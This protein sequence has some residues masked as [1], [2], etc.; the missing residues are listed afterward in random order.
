MTSSHIRSA[1]RFGQGKWLLRLV[2]GAILTMLAFRT[3]DIFA[4][5]MPDN[6][7]MLR[8]QQV[9][10]LMAG[11]NWFDVDQARFLTPEGGEMHWSRL[12]DIFIAAIIYIARPFIGQSSAEALAASLWPLILL[13]WTMAA[14]V[15]VMRHLK[16][17]LA[18]QI[19][20]LVF[21]GTSGA[22]YS[23]WPGRIDHHGFVVALCL[24]AFAAAL[25][26]RLSAKSGI[27]AAICVA[28]MVTIALEGLPYAGSLILIFGGMWIV[29]G[30]RDGVRLTF[31]GLFLAI[32]AATF[33]TLDAPGWGP[34]R[35]VCDAYGTSH[36][37][38]LTVGGLLLMLLGIFGG[39]LESWRS[40]LAA[41]VIAGALTLAVFVWVQPACLGDPYAGVSDQVRVAW[42]SAV[43]E[44]RSLPR[45]W[46]DE[47]ARA[48]WQVGFVVSGFGAAFVMMLRAPEGQRVNR[49]ALLLLMTVSALATVWQI[50]GVT[51]S[52]VFAAIAAG[53][54]F[55]AAFAN[56]QEQRG[57]GP[58][59]MLAAVALA[60]AP[61]TWSVVS[62]P[63]ERP[64]QFARSDKAYGEL[65]LD[66]KSYAQ[67][68]AF[69]SMRVF[70]PI[71]LGMSVLSR[72]EHDVFAGPYH[73]NVKGI[74]QVTGIFMG[75]SLAAQDKLLAMG[76]DH[77]LYCQGLNETARYGALAADSF[78]AELEA[79]ELPGWLIAVDGK[80]K[81]DGVVR[82]Y[83]IEDPTPLER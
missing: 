28:A 62:K 5:A 56:W 47:P 79:G 80:T 26:P 38:A 10:D 52:H 49:G 13:A 7:D 63:Y 72:T 50:R 18:G 61:M 73:R 77:V 40:R 29:R 69:G 74:E 12:P 64:S 45:L 15:C 55:G 24:T 76:A 19:A 75:P 68:N 14:S 66:P 8:L 43:G 6:D 23:F 22:I 82:L 65:C 9:R 37:A 60:I 59:L 58:V 4:G 16:L 70:T 46:A 25:S 44:A 21:I 27:A 34:E 30:H 36:F 35:S 71:D 20:G 78:A 51:F 1:D 54:A 2:G 39:A 33:Y 53:W 42:L 31:F 81:T 3:A 17:N 67:L 83:R 57:T 48:I 32:F 11:Q 41:S